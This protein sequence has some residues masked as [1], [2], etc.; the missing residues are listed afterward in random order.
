[1]KI[2]EK[3]KSWFLSPEE[4]D[5][6][7]S[8]KNIFPKSK[9]DKIILIQCP[10]DINYV[11][12]FAKVTNDNL[13]FKLV[14]V[15]PKINFP[16]IFNFFLMRGI[17]LYFIR[18]KWEKL[19]KKIGIDYFIYPKNI[20]FFDYLNN[21]LF[22]LKVFVNL[23]SKTELLELKY[24]GIK[25][26][27]LI[28]D[29]YLRYNKKA[30]VRISDPLLIFY[31]FLC[32]NQI[33][34]FKRLILI[35]GK[36]IISYYSSYSTYTSHGIPI[37][38]LLNNNINVFTLSTYVKNSL[39]YK[40]LKFPDFTHVKT[41]WNFIKLFEKLDCKEKL[42]EEGLKQFKKRFEGKN[43]IIYMKNDPFSIQGGKIKL[44]IKLEGVVFLHDFFDSPHIY[45]SMVFE[46]FY[47]WTV[48]TLEYALKKNLKIGF[49]PHPNQSIESKNLINGLKEKYPSITWIDEN[50]SNNTIFNSGIKFGVSVYGSVLP[51]LAFHKI[52]PI[53]C[54]DNPASSFNFIFEAKSKKEYKNLL[55]NTN[56]LS[57]QKDLKSQLGIYFYM[58]Y[59]HKMH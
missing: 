19:Y 44:G 13:S 16:S 7:N 53:C 46:D 21:F 3:F 30:T 43:K 45:N 9:S 15:H 59:L 47:E 11:N 17:H 58:N 40:N 12:E 6:I 14:G 37:R 25:C 23:K 50:T 8:R 24:S 38:I 26:G 31:F 4:K 29:S 51:E 55:L 34:A 57:F 42:I 27:D 33:S 41:H 32:F 36:N 5:F 48:Y 39:A 2:A 1:M 56:N 49:K 54:G 52:I 10:Q 18:R 35:N 20:I 28:Y 22:A